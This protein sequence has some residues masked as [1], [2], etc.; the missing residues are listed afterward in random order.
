MDLYDA[1]ADESMIGNITR[2]Q[3]NVYLLI[4]NRKHLA[5]HA[6]TYKLLCKVYM[7]E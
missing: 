3:S 1:D 7:T 4:N 6:L 5:L 2:S